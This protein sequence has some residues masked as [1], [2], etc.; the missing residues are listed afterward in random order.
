MPDEKWEDVPEIT[1]GKNGGFSVDADAY[2]ELPE[3][4]KEIKEIDE[5]IELP[6]QDQ[7][8]NEG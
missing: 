5:M 7:S 1:V 6:K 2:F 4:K 3:I 8:T